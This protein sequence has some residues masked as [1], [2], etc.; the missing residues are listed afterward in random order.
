M[1]IQVGKAENASH[2]SKCS[3]LVWAG[4]GRG[5]ASGME[6][7]EMSLGMEGRLQGLHS[8]H[9]LTPTYN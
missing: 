3:C 7:L 8:V 5:T 1:K 4:G 2:V 9:R 6:F